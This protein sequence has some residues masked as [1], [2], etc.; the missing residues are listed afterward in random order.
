MFRDVGPELVD[1]GDTSM[2]TAVVQ[3]DEHVIENNPFGRI[4]DK[5][6][7]FNVRKGLFAGIIEETL[8]LRH[9]TAVRLDL[10]PLGFG[11]TSTARR[12]SFVEVSHRHCHNCIRLVAPM[13]FANSGSEHSW[14]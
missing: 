10:T 7:H 5:A 11:D 12:C 9:I 3:S 14:W 4:T 8:P 13:G 2:T 1:E 6:V